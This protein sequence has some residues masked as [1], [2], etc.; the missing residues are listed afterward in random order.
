[1]LE[2]DSSH[3]ALQSSREILERN[4][5]GNGFDSDCFRQIEG[6]AFLILDEMA[7]SHESFDLVILDPPALATRKKQKQTKWPT[8]KRLKQ[9]DPKEVEQK[10]LHLYFL[11]EH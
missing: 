5:Y 10:F 2:I 6:D 1:M 7:D 8:P 9:I 3:F 4:H 11:I